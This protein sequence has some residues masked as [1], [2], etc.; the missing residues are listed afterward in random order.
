[1]NRIVYRLYSERQSYSGFADTYMLLKYSL[2]SSQRRSQYRIVNVMVLGS[3]RCTIVDIEVCRMEKGDPLIFLSLRRL[4]YY[5]TW[6]GRQAE[7]NPPFSTCLAPFNWHSEFVYTGLY[8]H[9]RSLC[10]GWVR[11]YVDELGSRSKRRIKKQS[12][13]GRGSNDREGVWLRRNSLS[14]VL[15]AT[16]SVLTFPVGAL[17]LCCVLYAQCVCESGTQ[18]SEN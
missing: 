11:L 7:L 18:T 12:R 6:A 14:F 2:Y 3:K 10:I 9:F 13:N 4:I 16:G 1:M 15:R 17:K 8:C 5:I